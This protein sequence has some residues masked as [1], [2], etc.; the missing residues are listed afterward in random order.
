MAAYK[1]FPRSIGHILDN[2]STMLSSNTACAWS[3]RLHRDRRRSE[4]TQEF[5]RLWGLASD[6]QRKAVVSLRLWNVR[7]WP[8]MV[9]QL[10]GRKI[11]LRTFRSALPGLFPTPTSE[12]RAWP[13][14]PASPGSCG[15]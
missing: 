9:S 11:G 7:S 5:M 6:D 13:P 4:E 15:R 14:L 2:A 3:T 8:K 12:M 1:S 10:L